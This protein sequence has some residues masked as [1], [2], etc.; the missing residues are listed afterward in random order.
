MQKLIF[1]FEVSIFLLGPLNLL[2]QNVIFWLIYLPCKP[3]YPTEVN[4]AEQQM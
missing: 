1:Y 3:K 2:Q 4:C